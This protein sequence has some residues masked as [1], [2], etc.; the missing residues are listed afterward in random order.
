MKIVTEWKQD[1]KFD[2]QLDNAVIKT[3]ARLDYTVWF[4]IAEFVDN[5]IQSYRNHKKLLDSCFAREDKKRLTVEIAYDSN[6]D[7]LRITDNSIGMNFEELQKALEAGVP[8]EFTNGLSEFGMGLKTASCWLSDTWRVK[9]K[10]FGEDKEFEVNFSVQKVAM[11]ETELDIIERVQ[12]KE[13]HYTII[14]IDNLRRKIQSKTLTKTKAYLS[15]IYRL[16]TRANEDGSGP[17]MDLYWDDRPLIYDANLDIL[18]ANDPE[19]TP[20]KRSFDFE[21]N[22][23]RVYGWCAVLRSGGRPVAGFAVIRRGRLIY[24]QPSAWRPEALYGQEQGSNDTVNQRLVGEIHLDEFTPSHTKNAILWEGDEEDEINEKLQSLFSDY[25]L[26]AKE[27]KDSGS[28]PS[29]Q[30]VDVALDQLE[31]TLTSPAFSDVVTFTP[32]PEPERVRAANQPLFEGVVDSEADKRIQIGEHTLKIYL[33]NNF[34]T[35]DPYFAKESPE[36]KTLIVIINL[37]HPFFTGNLQEGESVLTYMLMCCY[38]ALAEWKCEFHTG[39]IEPDTVR[40]VKDQ[41]MRQAI[42]Q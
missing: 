30:T 5:S 1:M 7:F 21:V 34:S 31:A 13:L 23:K 8:P 28:G 10:K 41:F 37:Q 33:R 11:G 20:Y 42:S 27:R 15:S 39:I 22:G 2:F 29:A 36:E 38:D 35:N 40:Q 17:I 26:K 6:R 25:R 12:S 18:K 32:V 16:Q 24:G 14:E 4:A 19:Q 3:W 9:T